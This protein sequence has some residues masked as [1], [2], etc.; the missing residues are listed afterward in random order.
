MMPKFKLMLELRH[1]VLVNITMRREFIYKKIETDDEIAGAKKLIIEYTEWLN[2]DLSF[3]DID[4]EL[5]HF[6]KKYSEPDGSFIIAK[7]GTLTVG[8]VGFR[9]LEENICEMKRLY[10]IDAY[11]GMGIGKILVEKIIAEAAQKNYKKMRLDTINTMKAALNI[12]YQSG[13]YEIEAY[14]HNP[15]DNIVYLEKELL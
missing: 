10:V 1:F 9:K 2:Q 13:F 15:H 7:D 12:Y 3:Q 4:D 6:P 14:Y 8:C 11:K 5:R